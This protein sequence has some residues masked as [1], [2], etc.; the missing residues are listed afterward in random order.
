MNIQQMNNK[1]IL[2]QMETPLGWFLFF[3]I[4]IISRRTRHERHY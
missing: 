3:I 1:P 2:G 4:Q